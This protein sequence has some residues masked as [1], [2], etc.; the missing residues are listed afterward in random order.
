MYPASILASPNW[1]QR[2]LLHPEL[3]S[4]FPSDAAD[5]GIA[6]IVPPASASATKGA[7]IN[8]QTNTKQEASKKL[9]VDADSLL[10]SLMG[11]S[12]PLQAMY[13]A[14]ENGAYLADSN[15]PDFASITATAGSSSKAPSSVSAEEHDES[16]SKII[17][18]DGNCR[19]PTAPPIPPPKPTR[20]MMLVNAGEQQEQQAQVKHMD[21][22]PHLFSPSSSTNECQENEE[23]RH[24]ATPTSSPYAT[25]S[26]NAT[27]LMTK[28]SMS[29][30]A[31]R[32]S[33]G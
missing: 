30:S 22:L 8:N 11:I 23:L 32:C 21:V 18:A 5:E 24:G 28:S 14:A 26:L 6:L 9:S 20:L 13:S 3:Q 27:P 17:A 12:S 19:R 4:I 29:S 31:G 2:L 33:G 25:Y 7:D 15:K 10:R 16:S 1:Q